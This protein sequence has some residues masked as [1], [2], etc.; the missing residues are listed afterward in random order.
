MNNG[1]ACDDDNDI[2]EDSCTNACA[3]ATCGDGYVHEGEQ[4]D[5]GQLNSDNPDACRTNCMVATCGDGI[6]DE[7]E[8]CD[9]DNTSNNDGCS[10]TCEVEFCG[11]SVTQS[12]E[13]CDDG[14]DN[15]GDGCTSACIVEVCGD[16]VVNNNQSEACDDGN[17]TPGDGCNSSCQNEYCGD[18]IVNNGRSEACDDGGVDLD[19]ENDTCSDECTTLQPK[20]KIVAWKIICEDESDLPNWGAG[21]EDINEAT[22]TNWVENSDGA[23]WFAPNRSFQWG[24]NGGVTNPGDD[25]Y[26]E[27]DG[28]WSTFGGTDSEGMTMVEIPL[29]EEI[30]N[31]WMREVNQ[32]GYIPFTY[33][34]AGN[35][36]TN[37]VSAEIY[38]HND[39]LNYDNFDRIDLDGSETYYCVA[40]NT[41]SDYCGDG[42]VNNDETCDDGELNGSAP[43]ACNYSCNGEVPPYCGN[44]E[45]N[46]GEQC[47][48]AYEGE[49]QQPECRQD[50]TIPV[51]GDGIV[52]AEE[53]CDDGDDLNGNSC[54]NE[55]TTNRGG[56]GSSCTVNCD[57]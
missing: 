13:A 30:G 4:C 7:D 1:E 24:Y 53:Q 22:A 38:C 18:G 25:L 5:D 34:P 57:G 15:D 56:G 9:D 11:D 29:Y 32:E 51:C 46:E 20:A 6:I 23:C 21:A 12:N 35:S 54:S 33:G 43:G 55:C 27:A 36:N 40:F 14:N 19:A 37:D 10:A 39:V 3:L 26:G 49:G 8:A 31:L 52:D 17:T 50:C 45:L 2:N 47:D 16:G 48:P 28:S 44:G 42:E 41:L